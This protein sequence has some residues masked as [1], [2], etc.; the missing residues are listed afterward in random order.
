MACLLG[1]LAAFVHAQCVNS[2]FLKTLELAASGDHACCHHKQE[3]KSC[4][5][6]GPGFVTADEITPDG[7]TDTT[8]ALTTPGL[9]LPAVGPVAFAPTVEARA[10]SPDQRRQLPLRI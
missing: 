2:C 7:P 1:I 9:L 4:P 10:P 5:Q 3:K 6:A 8:V